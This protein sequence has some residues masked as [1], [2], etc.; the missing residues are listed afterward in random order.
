MLYTVTE[1]KAATYPKPL[2]VMLSTTLVESAYMY[3]NIYL[4][5]RDK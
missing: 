1:N 2:G 3:N 4:S 5:N